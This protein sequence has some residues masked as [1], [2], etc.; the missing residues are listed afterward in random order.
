MQ[1]K[2]ID[3]IDT[4]KYDAVLICNLDECINEDYGDPR[5]FTGAGYGKVTGKTPYLWYDDPRLL[6]NY[7][8]MYE[9]KRT[10]L[11]RD[12]NSYNCSYGVNWN[13]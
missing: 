4:S 1:L 10:C 13:S 9:K 2:M 7:E 6:D 11:H 3:N 5:S 12:F 8:R